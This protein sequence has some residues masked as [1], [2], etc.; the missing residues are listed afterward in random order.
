MVIGIY[1]QI[2]KKLETLNS[3]SLMSSLSVEADFLPLTGMSALSPLNESVMASSE[4]V[5][6]RG[7]VDFPLNLLLP[8]LFASR[9]INYTRPDNPQ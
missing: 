8:H 5:A 7:T 9:P 4:V 1:G 6:L 2:L 3:H